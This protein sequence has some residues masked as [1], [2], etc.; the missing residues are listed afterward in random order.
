MMKSFLEDKLSQRLE[1]VHRD[2]QQK[3]ERERQA[4]QIQQETAVRV[5]R[6]QQKRKEKQQLQEQ[7]LANTTAYKEAQRSA[8]DNNKG[9]NCECASILFST[10]D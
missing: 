8:A 2:W 5:M 6:K 1:V 4:E 9:R 10:F 3:L 7:K